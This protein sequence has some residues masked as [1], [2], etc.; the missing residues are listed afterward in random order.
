MKNFQKGF[1]V[2]LL[3]AVVVLVTGGGIFLYTKNKQVAHIEISS[4]TQHKLEDITPSIETVS[5]TTNT[6]LVGMATASSSKEIFVFG[7]NIVVDP[8][9][10]QILNEGYGNIGYA[11][12]KNHVYY[13]KTDYRGRTFTLFPDI[14]VD[15]ETFEFFSAG[16][17][18]YAKDKNHI[19]FEG[20][21]TSFNPKTFTLFSNGDYM[22]DDVKVYY[23]EKKIEADP[24]T[25]LAIKE[26][27]WFAKDKDYVFF[28]GVPIV[29]NPKN[30]PPPDAKSFTPLDSAYAKD[31]SR[32]YYIERYDPSKGMSVLVE[33]DTK[34]FTS[35]GTRISDKDA[36]NY[37]YAKD[38][39]HVYFFGRVLHGVDAETF[40]FI[41]QTDIQS[42]ECVG[43]CGA[44]VTKDKQCIYLNNEKVLGSDGLC[45]NPSQ[46]TSA[47]TNTSCGE[48]AERVCSS[49]GAS[50]D[51]CV[52][53][54]NDEMN[55]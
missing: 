45:I 6:T 19:Y 3:I 43:M 9:T 51:Q 24:A 15:T 50:R 1:I 39:S 47:T 8:A 44:I 2:P 21:I 42:P 46:C 23:G 53:W 20:K 7:T 28:A 11:K 48:T 27:Q 4:T 18:K 41:G 25:F 29:M 22:K 10:L 31:I 26:V 14:N 52:K 17:N 40:E 34:T 13:L 33:A 12:D 16:H 5:T 37:A 54:I 32:V 38:K 49:W 35:L 30:L 36:T 55:E